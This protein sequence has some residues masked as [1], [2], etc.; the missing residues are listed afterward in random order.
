MQISE[1]LGVWATSLRRF[2]C[3]SNLEPYSP[4]VI[5]ITSIS[6]STVPLTLFLL[7]T[8]IQALPLNIQ[9]SRYLN[10]HDN[11]QPIC[12]RCYLIQHSLAPNVPVQQLLRQVQHATYQSVWQ[13]GWTRQHNHP[14]HEALSTLLESPPHILELEDVISIVESSCTC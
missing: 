10:P 2:R 8:L 5:I 11:L 7:H 9:S 4:R 6:N 12:Y 1:L 3:I 13:P 14:N